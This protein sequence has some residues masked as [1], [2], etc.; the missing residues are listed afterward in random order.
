V[1]EADQGF[2]NQAFLDDPDQVMVRDL[3]LDRELA[4]L[5][6]GTALDLG[7]G[8]GANALKLAAQGWSVTGV[9]W[10]ERAVELARQAAAAGGLDATF[11]LA[12]ITTWQPARQFD[13]VTSTYA[14]PGGDANKRVLHTAVQALAPDGTLLI[15]EWDKSMSQV[16]GFSEDELPSPREIAELLQGVTIE[17]VE[18]RRLD[19]LFTSDDLRAHEDTSANVAFVRA[20]KPQT[21][22]EES[23]HGKEIKRT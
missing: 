21:D 10:A 14:L 1:S 6:P 4:S 11:L 19:G 22:A 20:R 13:L 3:I 5:A 2:W 7:C 16:W 12:D 18:V 15:V 8:S 17:T 9:D 23:H